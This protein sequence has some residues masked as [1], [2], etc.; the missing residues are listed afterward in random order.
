MEHFLSIMEHFSIQHGTIFYLTLNNFPSKMEH[1]LIQHGTLS[2]QHGTIF[3][4]TWH[5][6]LSNMEQFSIQH[7]TLFN[8]MFEKSCCKFVSKYFNFLNIWYLKFCSFRKCIN[9]IFILH[10]FSFFISL[11]NNCIGAKVRR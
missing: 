1:F 8:P 7:G 9:F 4:P 11:L 10:I 3:Y 2:I 5:T 6:L